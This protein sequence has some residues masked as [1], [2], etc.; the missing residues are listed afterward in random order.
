MLAWAVRAARFLTV[1]QYDRIDEDHRREP[2]DKRAIWVLLAVALSMLLSRYAGR[3]SWVQQQPW[4]QQ[5]FHGLPLHPRIWPRLYWAL[6]KLV[7]YGLVSLLV[8]KLV[9]RERVRDY[10]LVGKTG[11]RLWLLYLGLFL[12]VLPFVYLASASPQFLAA[13]PK[14]RLAGRALH[15][16]LIWEAAYGLQFFLL[17]LFFRGFILFSLARYCGHIAIFIMVLPYTMIHFGKPMPEALGS[18]IAGIALGTLALRTRSIF[19]GVAIHCA[20][21][22]S[23]DLLALHRTG[24][25]ARLLRSLG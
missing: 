5:L 15:E 9:F 16:L 11:W 25:L 20:V 3:A 12:V 8:I 24:H 6:F 22:W 10:G 21:A 2:F 19:G 18:V 17:E 23:M 7:N 4:A 1:D 14:Y 13:Y